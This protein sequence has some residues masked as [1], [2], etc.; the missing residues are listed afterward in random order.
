[1]A[2][3]RQKDMK[4]SATVVATTTFAAVDRSDSEGT[5]SVYDIAALR[6]ARARQAA[7]SRIFKFGAFPLANAPRY[8]FIE[9]RKQPT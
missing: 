3:A 4:E 2:A 9:R 5:V 8:D 1:M 6:L 7:R